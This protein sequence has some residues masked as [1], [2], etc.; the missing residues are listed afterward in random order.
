M[1]SRHK[2]WFRIHRIDTPPVVNPATDDEEPEEPD[3]HY[4]AFWTI[5][6][7]TYRVHIWN[8]D[9]W[10]RQTPVLPHAVQA[11]SLNGRGWMSFQP[12][13]RR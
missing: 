3:T 9:E 13:D 2:P 6:D 8:H 7:K 11:R 5:E 10:E 4:R 1:V 12:I